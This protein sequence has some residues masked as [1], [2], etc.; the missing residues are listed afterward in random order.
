MSRSSKSSRNIAS[1]TA[2]F[3]GV[4]SWQIPSRPVLLWLTDAIFVALIV[5]FPFIMGGREAWG[6]HPTGPPKTLLRDDDLSVPSTRMQ[7]SPS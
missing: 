4:S 3:A 7:P 1:E 2:R 6:H 5:V